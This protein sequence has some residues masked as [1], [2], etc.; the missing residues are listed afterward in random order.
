MSDRVKAALRS[1]TGMKP[2]T[3]EPDPQV[4][5]CCKA[6]ALDIGRV[7]HLVKSNALHD[8]EAID[9]YRAELAARRARADEGQAEH[10]RRIGEH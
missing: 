9:A 8:Q 1:R 6:E 4:P 10:H 5:G 2:H 3:Y 7:C